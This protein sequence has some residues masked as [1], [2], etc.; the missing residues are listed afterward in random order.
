MWRALIFI[1]LLAL[2]AFAAVWLA[3]RP[4][5]LVVTWGGYEYRTTL[6]LAAVAIAALALVLA[7]LWSVVSTVLDLPGRLA[8]RSRA[9]RREK[10]YAAVSR[11]IVAVGAGDPTAAQ[12]HAGEAE[13]LL[14]GE[15]LTLLLRAQ[16]AQISGDRPAAEAAFRRMAETGETRVL[17]LRGLF[18]EAKRRGDMDAAR[19][20]AAEAARL[21]PTVGW[22]NEAVLEAQSADGDWRGALATIERRSSL[23]LVDKA[24][25]R[26]QRAVLLAADALERAE[27]DPDGA[28]EAALEATR[29]APDLV[30]AAALAGRLLSRRADLR[31]GSKVVENAWKLQPHPDL[32]E[33]YLDMRPGDSA[34]D[35]LH[36]A[37]T[38]AKLSSWD[39]EARLALSRAALDAR[40]FGRARDTLQPLLQERPTVRAYLL[41]ADIE[42]AEHGHT[43]RF[44]E[45]VARAAR[46]PRDPVWIADGV[47]SDKWAP[48][49]P[50]T[51]RLDAFEWRS[52]P[53][54]LAGPGPLVQEHEE[55]EPA[56][57]IPAPVPVEPAPAPSAAAA[58]AAA[59][60]SAAVPEAE[61]APEP[62]AATPA[63][64]PA[65]DEPPAPAEPAPP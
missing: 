7:L 21:A 35:R 16:A 41:M 43:G 1:A 33:V 45:L 42:Q 50:V 28:L 6:A 30:P 65:A 25:S 34:L 52:P 23:G 60:A 20:Y 55:P 49:S 39:P 61:A 63:E 57:A 22:A 27:R 12:R 59:T 32:A 9:R 19:A 40:E 8:R 56:R 2:A 58:A 29:L 38:L 47:V 17:G 44:R 37:E 4:G 24:T 48:I 31:R 3:D 46:A 18:I 13:R 15:P 14:G 53:D 54:L 36:R 51:G 10:G 64:W 62:Q 11:G 26:R 5:S